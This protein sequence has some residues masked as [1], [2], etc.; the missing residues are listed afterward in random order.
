MKAYVGID[1]HST[2]NYVGIINQNDKRLFQKRLP[3]NLDKVLKALSSFKK[4]IKG[5]AIESTYNWYWLVDGL[6]E[7]GYNVHL[8]N[9][10]A[11]KQYEGLKYTNDKHDAF[12]LAHML[13]LGI[14]PTGYIYPKE[15]RAVRDLLRKRMQLVQQ[16]TTQIL[17]IQNQLTR[18]T[19]EL[20]SANAI[21]KLTTNK[22]REYIDDE[23]IQLAVFSHL[24]I[25]NLLTTK[26]VTME[27]K[28]LT[29]IN[30]K[31]EFQKL[32]Q[33]PGIGSIIALTIMLE[34]GD[35]SRFKK[36][37]NFSS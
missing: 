35:I 23:N 16:R 13:R 27:K 30:L 33:I 1:L 17:C 14:L 12:H 2:N 28:V 5:S 34:T 29:Q 21:K 18:N 19:G 3:N 25:M 10:S 15:Q 31:P 8:A 32:L 26:I 7:A 9:P 4:Q 36:V 37:G 22:V 24:S 6:Q 20:F 11:I